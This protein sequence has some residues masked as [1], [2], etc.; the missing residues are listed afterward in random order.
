MNS[1]RF[2]QP[3]T[4]QIL[5]PGVLVHTCN[6]STPE[7][8]ERGKLQVQGQLDLHSKF[9]ASQRYIVRLSQTNKQNHQIL[10]GQKQINK[11]RFKEIFACLISLI[12]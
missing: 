8:K 7:A 3:L 6:A 9:Q 10:F 5:K 12:H 11:N 2:N 4:N 1:N